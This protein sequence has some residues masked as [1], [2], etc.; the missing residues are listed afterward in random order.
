MDPLG[1]FWDP[2][3]NEWC[4]I[5]MFRGPFA[6]D[7]IF[8]EP[9]KKEAPWVATPETLPAIDTHFW[10]WIWWLATKDQRGKADLVRDELDK[11]EWF[12]LAPLGV[13]L[14]ECTIEAAVKAYGRS[15]ELGSEVTSGLRRLG[16][17]L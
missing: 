14:S 5:L 12:L 16:Y 2:L 4:Y 11:M 7:L 10:N 8:D 15:S 6:V 9:H 1:Q 3:S 13:T 17:E